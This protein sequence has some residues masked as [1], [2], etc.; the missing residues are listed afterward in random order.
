[1]TKLVEMFLAYSNYY[2]YLQN[3]NKKSSCPCKQYRSLL[4][5]S[6]ALNRIMQEGLRVMEKRGDVS[7]LQAWQEQL[8]GHAQWAIT[9]HRL[10]EKPAFQLH[11]CIHER[12]RVSG[13]VAEKRYPL[14]PT[15]E[16][17]K[18][19]NSLC[20][21]ILHDKVEHFLAQTGPLIFFPCLLLWWRTLKT[22]RIHDPTYYKCCM[23]CYADW[24]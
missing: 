19:W 8:G 17:I 15:R 18:S 22:Y 14:F 20:I 4:F 6:V 10:N 13:T 11:Q 23:L 12:V 3:E 24:V 9:Q 21:F 2:W 5:H 16:P 7:D 1:M